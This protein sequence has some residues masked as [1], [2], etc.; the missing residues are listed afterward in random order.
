VSFDN[1]T[2]ELLPAAL[3]AAALLSGRKDLNHRVR[4]LIV[5][6][7]PAFDIHSRDE[8]AEALTSAFQKAGISVCAQR[9]IRGDTLRAASKKAEQWLRA[10]IFLLSR[11]DV[12][13]PSAWMHDLP[14]VIFAV[15]NRSA[16]EVPAAAILN[17]RKP[18]RITP[19]DK[20]LQA[21]KRLVHL[22]IAEGFAIVSS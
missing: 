5:S 21:T 9:N 2:P 12:K 16:L 10:G 20:W 4:A 7:V 19:D 3:T 17:S 6:H 1:L 18:R 8:A 11:D 14:Q 22:A 13:A 15:G